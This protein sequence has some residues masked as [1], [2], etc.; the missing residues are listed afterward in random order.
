MTMLPRGLGPL[1]LATIAGVFFASQPLQA[2]TLASTNADNRL[3]V[4]F[5]VGDAALAEFMPDGWGVAPFGGGPFAGADLILVFIDSHR[6]VDPEGNPKYG[7]RYR[8]MAVAAPAKADGSDETAFMVTHV[9]VSDATINPYQN[10]VGARVT[11]QIVSTG[12]G[13]EA[14]SARQSWSV[15]PETGGEVALSLAWPA[16]VPGLSE[17][18]SNIRSAVDPELF[19]I[20]RYKQYADLVKSVPAEVDRVE[21][22]ALDVS[23]PELAPLFD[24]TETLVGILDVPWYMR[25]I[26]LP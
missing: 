15:A 23:I 1:C 6:T 22:L 12:T 7:G 10:S 21:S 8:G 9:Y 3:L 4:A 2:E 16:G 17:G 18:E 19:R 13:S 11:R 14:A 26:W 20:Y 5:D 24:G 25:E